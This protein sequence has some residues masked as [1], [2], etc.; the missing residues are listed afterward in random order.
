MGYITRP[1]H[2]EKRCIHFTYANYSASC[3][4]PKDGQTDDFLLLTSCLVRTEDKSSCSVGILTTKWG[5]ALQGVALLWAH[6]SRSIVCV[7][8]LWRTPMNCWCWF[9]SKFYVINGVFLWEQECGAAASRNVSTTEKSGKHSNN[10]EGGK[11]NQGRASSLLYPAPCQQTS[12]R[13]L[14][15]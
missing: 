7:P 11:E 14:M 5:C 3:W 10:L 9:S 12:A 13:P 2:K 15:S 8:F 6:V 4:E 1:V